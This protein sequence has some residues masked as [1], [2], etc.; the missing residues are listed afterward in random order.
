MLTIDVNRT[1]DTTSLVT[2]NRKV[3]QLRRIKD[4]RLAEKFIAN[5]YR[6]MAKYL[7][8]RNDAMDD[9]DSSAL[10]YLAANER[11]RFYNNV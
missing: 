8:S 2:T 11:L 4:C 10:R 7:G 3:V 9:I 6:T 5:D 1:L